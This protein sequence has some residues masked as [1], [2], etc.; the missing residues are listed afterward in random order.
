MNS[1]KEQKTGR[2]VEKKQEEK[3]EDMI[4]KRQK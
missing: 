1:R 2:R 3:E 4:Y